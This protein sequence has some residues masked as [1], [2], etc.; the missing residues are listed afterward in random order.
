[1]VD[2][3][4]QRQPLI[5]KNSGMQ[6]V[7]H[8]IKLGRSTFLIAIE[9]NTRWTHVIHKVSKGNMDGFIQRLNERMV[10]GIEWLER[11]INFLK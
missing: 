5:N 1:M 11:I 6:W 9:V 8:A 4:Q 2:T 7:I 10:N 3:I